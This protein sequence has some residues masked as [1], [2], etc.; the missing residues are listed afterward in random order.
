MPHR[1]CIFHPSTTACASGRPG[2]AARRPGLLGPATAGNRGWRVVATSAEAL[3]TLARA[4]GEEVDPAALPAGPGQDRADGRLEA[5]VGVGGDQ[6]HPTEP[7]ALSERR[8][9][10]QKAP[11]SLSPTSQPSTSRPP[12]AVTQGGDH[13]RPRHHPAVHPGLAV[14]GVHE[15]LRE[16]G[17]RQRPAA[18]GS[19][20]ASNSVQVREASL[21][22]IRA[23]TPKAR[24]RSSTLRVECRAR[25]PPPPPPAAPGR[26]AGAAPAA[27]RRT[28]PPAAWGSEARRR[29]P[30]RQQP[31]PAAVAV[32][33]PGG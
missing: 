17:V 9:A 26:C 3:G 31:R 23:S 8:N 33:G 13:H 32:G 25:R 2:S 29:R 18:E 16:G 15:H 20:P 12:S 11:S 4:F 7:R 6:L 10:V 1:P 21:L 14:G 28:S 24:T 19:H 30:C 22:A 27:T 5:G